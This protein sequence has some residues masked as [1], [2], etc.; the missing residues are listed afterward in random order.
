M[1]PSEIVAPLLNEY[2]YGLLLM[3]L[4]QTVTGG[5]KIQ[6][7]PCYMHIIQWLLWLL[8]FIIALPLIGLSFVWNEYYLATLYGTINCFIVF[9]ISSTIRL[10]NFKTKSYRH[11]D[12]NVE[13]T[14]FR[15]CYQVT[16]FIFAPKYLVNIIIHAII[17]GLT[18]FAGFILLDIPVLLDYLPIP[19]IV[20]VVIFG[21]ITLSIAHYS[22]L[23]QPPHEIM[24]YRAPHQDRFQL[25]F[26]QRPVY[27]IILG[28]VFIILR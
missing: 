17:S 15:H 18:C 13:N 24:I 28:V 10:V 2:K 19:A 12:S 27:I 6:R 7:V 4:A 1:M 23:V 22:L 14:N 3:R 20:F 8:P 5:L 11:D 9:I 26:I 25:R 16:H 21:W